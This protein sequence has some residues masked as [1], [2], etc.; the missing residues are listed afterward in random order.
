MTTTQM[1]DEDSDF[2]EYNDVGFDEAFA[3]LIESLRYAENGTK[4][5]C[6]HP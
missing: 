1:R 2:D 6:R 4:I 3:D 5:S